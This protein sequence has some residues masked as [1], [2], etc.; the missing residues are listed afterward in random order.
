MTQTGTEVNNTQISY[1]MKASAEIEAESN[2]L[3]KSHTN[4]NPDTKKIE[5]KLVVNEN[6]TNLGN[7]VI[8]DQ[9]PTGLSC[10]SDD[11]AA[12]RIGSDP[13]DQNNNTF[14]VE[15]DGKIVILLKNVTAE[16]TIT[17]PTTVDTDGTEFRENAQ[18]TFTN[19]AQFKSDAYGGW[20]NTG[21]V[22]AVIGNKALDKTTTNIDETNRKVSYRV[23]LNPTGIDLLKGRPQGSKLYITDKLSEGLYLDLDSVKLY[24]AR[25]TSERDGD[26]YTVKLDENAGIAAPL[27]ST[28]ILRRIPSPWR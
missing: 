20:L 19:S 14:T 7:V 2:V 1:D 4:Y 16:Q 15:G 28:T 11:I 10:T 25:R 24:E 9:L 26:Q 8:E 17:F 5:W 21:E 3:R 12:A 22:S 27:V 23:E 6:R 13:F 18:V